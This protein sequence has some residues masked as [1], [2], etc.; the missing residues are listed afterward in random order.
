MQ[1]TNINNTTNIFATMFPSLSQALSYIF[2]LKLLAELNVLLNNYARYV[3]LN[4][5]CALHLSQVCSMD[6]NLEFRP[7]FPYVPTICF[8]N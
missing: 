3:W 2:F 5:N 8:T 4:L 1:N 6:T 7:T